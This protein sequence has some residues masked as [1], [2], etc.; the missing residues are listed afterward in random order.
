[1]NR[2]KLDWGIDIN[3]PEEFGFAKNQITPFNLSTPD[4][5]TLYAWHI[6]PA[7]VYAKHEEELLHQQRPSA[8]RDV[9]STP[10]FQLLANDPEARLIIKCKDLIFK[11]LIIA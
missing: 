2:L 7:S 5:E 9:I 4:G 10:G 11:C 8:T 3:H 1:M 6:L